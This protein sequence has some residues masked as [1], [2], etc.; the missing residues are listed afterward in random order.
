RDRIGAVDAVEDVLQETL[1]HAWS[2]LRDRSPRHVRAWLYQVARNRCADFLRSAQRR[3]RFV[4]SEDL[5]TIINRFGV[6]VA[7][8]R[9]A[10]EDVV[11]A[12][13]HVPEKERAALR[14]FYLDG[15]SIAEIAVR[16]RCPPGTIK[17][18]LS[19]GRDMVRTE[20]GVTTNRRSTAMS[21]ESR[22]GKETFPGIRPD[23]SIEQ[24]TGTP[25]SIDFR[26]LAW[27]FI[28]PEVGDRVRWADYEPTRDG[29]VWRLTEDKTAAA[30]RCAII[31]GR[32][33]VEIEIE[34]HRH[35]DREGLL[36]LNH[37]PEKTARHTRFWGCL[38]E[39]EVHWLAVESMKSDGTRE[40][41]TCLDEDFGWDWG[42]SPRLV[43]DKDYL[44]E[45]PDGSLAKNTDAPQVFSHGLYTV[46]I[47]DR[48]FECMRVF[49]IDE[50]ASERAVLVMAF[51]TRAGRTVL[52]RRYNGNLWGKREKPPHSWGVEMTW[53]ED[54]PH[55]DRLVID[56]VKYVHHYD[57]LTDV[58]CGLRA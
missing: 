12:F 31:H 24:N 4:E 46:R 42:M 11:D 21:A 19:H 38:T 7:R 26:E 13:D 40:L 1:V 54:L 34:E 29:T 32:Q 6:P 43:E 16:H 48:A 53:E 56:G 27:W 36:P 57:S 25:F 49:D 5:A 37:D 30:S 51:V 9:R 18:R 10:A 22:T 20:L 28:V 58:A 50:D 52:F 47:G 35:Q 55:T 41:L 8:Q 44:T 33:C 45:Q 2:G 3:E 17:R 14:S 39:T 23:I 15:L